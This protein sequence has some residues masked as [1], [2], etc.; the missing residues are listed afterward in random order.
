MGGGA[1]KANTGDGAEGVAG[2]LKENP[3]VEGAVLAS[4]AFCP[5]E[6]PVV[7]GAGADSWGFGCPNEKPVDG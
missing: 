2:E 5:K 1:P 4:G 7:T 3:L 6:N